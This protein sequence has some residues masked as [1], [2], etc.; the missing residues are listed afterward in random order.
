MFMRFTTQDLTIRNVP[1]LLQQFLHQSVDSKANGDSFIH[2]ITM[3]CTAGDK[4]GCIQY[5]S[6]ITCIIKT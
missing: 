3:S 5:M 1:Q 4:T 2:H 6:C